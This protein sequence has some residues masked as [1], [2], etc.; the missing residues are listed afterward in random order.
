MFESNAR[1]DT[2]IETLDVDYEEI[3]SLNKLNVINTMRCENYVKNCASQNLLKK[4]N[5]WSQRQKEI[6]KK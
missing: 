1:D 6:L 4:F 5:W 3:E 2:I